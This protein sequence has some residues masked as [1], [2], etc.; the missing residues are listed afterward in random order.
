MPQLAAVVCAALTSTSVSD[1]RRSA[2][3]LARSRSSG[4]TCSCGHLHA[5]RL[6]Q[7]GDGVD[8][9]HAGVFGEEADGVA[10]GAAAEAVIELLAGLTEKLGDFS[11]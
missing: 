5:H 11:A 10:A 9:A 8:E 6:R 1:R 4:L 2:Q 3:A 7:I